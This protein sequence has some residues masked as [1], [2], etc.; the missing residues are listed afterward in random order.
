M[1]D[2]RIDMVKHNDDELEATTADETEINDS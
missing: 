2:T 1:T